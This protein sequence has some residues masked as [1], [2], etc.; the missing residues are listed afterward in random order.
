M[1]FW[2]DLSYFLPKEKNLFV[3]FFFSF[4][5]TFLDPVLRK[6]YG[7]YISVETK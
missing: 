5:K 7:I 3:P 4:I 1:H 6:Y 2:E